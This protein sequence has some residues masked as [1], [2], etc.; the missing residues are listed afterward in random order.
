MPKVSGCLSMFET[1]IILDAL[2]LKYL[3]RACT[4]GTASSI[5][6]AADGYHTTDNPSNLFQIIDGAVAPFQE[7][8]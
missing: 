4:S 7:S 5:R 3:A 2:G 1:S 8:Y 6:L